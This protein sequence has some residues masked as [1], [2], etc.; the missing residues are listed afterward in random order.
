M[1]AKNAI[2]REY[3]SKDYRNPLSTVCNHTGVVTKLLLFKS[4]RI[5]S[6]WRWPELAPRPEEQQTMHMNSQGQLKICHSNRGRRKFSPSDP[7][8]IFLHDV[9]SEGRRRKGH[10]VGDGNAEP[11]INFTTSIANNKLFYSIYSAPF[12]FVCPSQVCNAEKCLLILLLSLA[13]FVR[14]QSESLR[15]CRDEDSSQTGQT[16]D[17]WSVIVRQY[18][19]K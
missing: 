10:A 7:P 11:S 5:T 8:A 16:T 17:F 9:Q 15:H 6:K 12:C 4:W 2:S 13:W 3:L 19:F 14:N 18:V 1:F